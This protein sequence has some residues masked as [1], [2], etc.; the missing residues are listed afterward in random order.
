VFLPCIHAFNDKQQHLIK[1]ALLLLDDSMSAWH[2]KTSKFGGL[3]NYTFEPRKPVPLR[4][5]FQN[6]AE[7][8][9]GVLVSQDIIQ[10]SKEQA[11]KKY[12]N[13]KSS[14]PGDLSFITAHA[15][16]V[17][18]QVEGAK[19]PEGDWVGGDSWFGSVLSAGEVKHNLLCIQ[20]GLSNRIQTSFP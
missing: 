8:M 11:R 20:L 14:L 7:C 5:M 6:V 17:L 15:A 12:F 3:P 19:G 1:T 2:P 9:S 18:Q 16:E 13:E 4:T 10:L